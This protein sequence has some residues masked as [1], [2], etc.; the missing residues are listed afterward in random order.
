MFKRTVLAAS[1]ATALSAAPVMAASERGSDTWAE[2]SITTAYTLNEHLNPFDLDVEVVNGTA[3][4]TGSVESQ[5]EK[6]LAEQIAL[7][8]DGVQR[9]DNGL[10]IAGD[11]PRRSE[12]GSFSSTVAD[13]SVTAR[14]KSKLLWNQSTS[15]LG[16]DVTTRDGVVALEGN[17]KSNAERD[18]VRQIATN[19]HGVRSI[20][21]QLSVKPAAD[22]VGKQ[23]DTNS[24]PS[25]ME[26]ASKLGDTV[27]DAWITAKV[28]SAL[29]YN[30]AVDGTAVDVDT[31]NGVVTLTGRVWDKHERDQAVFVTEGIIGVKSVRDNLRVNTP[32][33]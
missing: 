20:D 15:G 12:P 21:D 2:A 10:K 29:L 8:V 26:A 30:S 7:G 22:P 18:L 31:S 6:D 24:N 5:I 11:A 28:K 19:T 1:L 25:P 27:S 23:A 4:L 3:R 33:S 9:V 13:A 16:I 14:V 17:V 32:S